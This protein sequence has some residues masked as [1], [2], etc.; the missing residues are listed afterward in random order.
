[1]HVVHVTPH[2]PPDQAANALLPFHLGEWAHEVGDDVSYIAHP[3]REHGIAT[4]PGPVV[5]I[6]RPPAARTSLATLRSLREAARIVRL[7]L[8]AL[9]QADL[10]HVH[11]N[12]LLAELGVLLARRLGKPV[13]LTLY[14]TEIWH[15]RP[16]SVDLFAR[17]YRGASRVTFYSRG[18]SQ[19]ADELGLK[20]AGA[21][22]IYP[23]VTSAFRWRDR[24][25]QQEARERLGLTRRH[26]LINVKRLHPLAGQRFLID[27]MPQVLRAHEDT[28]LIV[29]GS[30]QLREELEQRARMAGVLAHVV[31]L[32][33]VSNEAVA[34]YCS[35]ADVFV[36]P[37]LLEA[38]PTVAV[39]ALASGV[40]V[41]SADNPGGVELHE[42]FGDDVRV[43][44]GQNVHA[45]A[46]AIN[47]ELDAGRRTSRETIERIAREFSPDVVAGRFRAVYASLF[48]P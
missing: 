14:G 20:H 38:C 47:E 42:I 2:L 8:P 23:P 33:Q 45:L 10:V 5:S 18:L 3:P 9:R 43:V 35:A 44:P 46:R 32:G 1:M 24:E 19:R 15:Y 6:P 25:G 31:F 17:A 41:I 13:V 40:P 39:E 7:A 28:V 34:A 27:A 12:G 30:G 11:S 4:L 29:C 26:V 21:A 36:L 22:V 37:S 16:K 48:Q